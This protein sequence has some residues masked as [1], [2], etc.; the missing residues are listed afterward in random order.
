M[1]DVKAASADLKPFV[2]K[3]ADGKPL[4]EAEAASAF[5]I[6]MSG[7][8]TPGQIGAFLMALRLRGE[9]VAE[10]TGAARVMRAKALH[11][12]AP[13]NAIDTCGTGGDGDH[14]LNIST[15]VAM[16]IA[17]CGIPVAKHGNRAASSKSGT[18]DVL[19]ALGV[20]GFN[21]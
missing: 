5:E 11:V 8:A 14:T 9:T 15:A 3:V 6:I 1:N 13:A 19:Q 16:V 18:A 17:A 12:Q 7:A 2:A 10:I 4:S 21:F 20:N